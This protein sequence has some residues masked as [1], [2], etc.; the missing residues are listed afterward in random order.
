L[1][2]P[3]VEKGGSHKKA[4]LVPFATDYTII[5]DQVKMYV[6]FFVW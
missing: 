3:F 4:D 1:L 6:T 5:V 2:F